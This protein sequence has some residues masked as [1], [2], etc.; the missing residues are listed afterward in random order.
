MKAEIKE[1]HTQGGKV[2]NEKHWCT[3]KTFKRLR[4]ELFFCLIISSYPKI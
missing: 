3:F 2:H 1:Q 4:K